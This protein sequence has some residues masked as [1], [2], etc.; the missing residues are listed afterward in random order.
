MSRFPAWM[1]Y[2]CGNKRGEDV[3][4]GK[5]QAWGVLTLW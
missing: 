1:T 5:R 4:R 2:C 3:T